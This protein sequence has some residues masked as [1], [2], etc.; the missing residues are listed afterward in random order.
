M[1]SGL[2][3][4]IASPAFLGVHEAARSAGGRAPDRTRTFCSARR[5]ST[6]ALLALGRSRIGIAWSEVVALR[7][8]NLLLPDGDG[9]GEFVFSTAAPETDKQWNDNGKRREERQRK[10][11]AANETRYV[12]C[13]PVLVRILRDHFTDRKLDSGDR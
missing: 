2:R 10:Q 8:R 4:P 12:P 1:L 3:C 11:R 6:P 7:V 9:W 5:V 13:H